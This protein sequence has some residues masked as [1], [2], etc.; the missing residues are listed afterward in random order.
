[1]APEIIV[2]GVDVVPTV[3]RDRDVEGKRSG[4]DPPDDRQGR[5]GADWPARVN[6]TRSSVKPFYCRSFSGPMKRQRRDDTPDAD[7]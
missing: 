2:A 6:R 7:R 5:A 3:K 1:M 4:A